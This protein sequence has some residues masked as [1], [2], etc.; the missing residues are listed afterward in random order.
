MASRRERRE[1]RHRGAVGHRRTARGMHPCAIGASKRLLGTSVPCFWVPPPARPWR[2]GIG[3]S[4]SPQ[5][6]GWVQMEG[7]LSGYTIEAGF[8]GGAVWDD[9]LAG[10]VGMTVA[11]DSQAATRASYL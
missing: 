9:D 3:H 8:S 11:A 5:G 2:L 6:L 7:A 4:A 10:V 1:R